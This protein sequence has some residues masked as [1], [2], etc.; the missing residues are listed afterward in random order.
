MKQATHR[1]TIESESSQGFGVSQKE[2]AWLKMLLKKK[3]KEKRALSSATIK[4]NEKAKKLK[5]KNAKKQVYCTLF[6]CSHKT[7]KKVFFVFE[8]IVEK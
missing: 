3:R 2:I 8:K 7:N 1:A 6:C 5:G 4:R